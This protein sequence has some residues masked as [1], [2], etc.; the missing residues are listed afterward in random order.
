MKGPIMQTLSWIVAAIPLL[1][2]V[3]LLAAELLRLSRA[4]RQFHERLTKL[5]GRYFELQGENRELKKQLGM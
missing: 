4:N 2:I 1:V 3:L 5:C